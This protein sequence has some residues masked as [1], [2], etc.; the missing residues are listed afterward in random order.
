MRRPVLGGSL[1]ESERSRGKG[2]PEASL[3]GFFPGTKTR[4]GE[5]R[6]GTLEG[7]AEQGEGTRLFSRVGTVEGGGFCVK[8]GRVKNWPDRRKSPCLK[9]WP[10]CPGKKKERLGG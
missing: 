9:A 3:L 4:R 6:T 2:G 1:S 10:L 8:G 7:A 5:C